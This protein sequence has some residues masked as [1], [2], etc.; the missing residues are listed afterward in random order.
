MRYNSGPAPWGGCRRAECTAPW[1]NPGGMT[2]SELAV[3]AVGAALNE[4]SSQLV[5]AL[6]EA[7]PPAY[8][9]SA[10][11]PHDFPPAVQ[12][13]LPPPPPPPS[14]ASH[15]PQPRDARR[16]IVG[17]LRPPLHRVGLCEYSRKS[18]RSRGKTRA[19][20]ELLACC[21]ACG[22]GWRERRLAVSRPD[23][24]TATLGGSSCPA[25]TR[26]S[27]SG[28]KATHTNRRSVGVVEEGASQSE[29][30]ASAVLAGAHWRTCPVSAGTPAHGLYA[31][32][33]T[34]MLLAG[35]A[36]SSIRRERVV[37]AYAV[38]ITSPT[39]RNGSL[40]RLPHHGFATGTPWRSDGSHIPRAAGQL[41]MPEDVRRPCASIN[42]YIYRHTYI[43]ASN[44]RL[45]VQ[46]SGRGQI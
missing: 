45:I 14:Y 21:L 29:E 12:H 13:F 11:I 38:E 31:S 20:Q 18:F 9:P 42:K 19:G 24:R 27:T 4:P 8:P 36:K 33:E 1:H 39:M 16:E 43:G 44:S 40:T 7:T 23:R 30:G 41:C 37:C 3:D 22:E 2:L 28:K 32:G 46:I 15:H 35:G 17:H 34:A 5:E 10:P 25:T 26:T 6:P